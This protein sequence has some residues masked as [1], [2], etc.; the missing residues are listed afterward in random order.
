MRVVDVLACENIIII[1]III[2]CN[3]IAIA[4]APTV[5]LKHS[6]AITTRGDNGLEPWLANPR[7][8]SH[9]F[10]LKLL[11]LLLLLFIVVILTN[12]IRAGR[13]SVSCEL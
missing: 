5:N 9:S 8:R 11:L 4:N 10:T 13:R 6:A 1:I 3:T 2:V 7:L 12:G